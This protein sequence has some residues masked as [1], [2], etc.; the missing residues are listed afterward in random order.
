MARRLEGSRVGHAFRERPELQAALLFFVVASLLLVFAVLGEEI[1]EGETMKFDRSLA[2]TLR[3][4]G[5]GAAWTAEAARDLTSLG[6]TAVLGLITG[7]AVLYLLLLK[8]RIG[9]AVVFSTV[10]GGQILSSSLK[11]WFDRARP[12]LLPLPPNLS[13][14]FPSGH[15]M[16]S[17]VTYLTI[18]MLLT[19][20]QPAR[21]IRIFSVAVAVLM[22][23][24]VGLSRVYL[25][26]HWPTDVLGGWCLGSAWALLFGGF[27]MRMAR[28]YGAKVRA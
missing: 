23:V 11:A 25:G 10:F 16:M 7:V 13:A 5:A 22:I 12:D 14:S 2:N 21:S 20:T 18:A 8:D 27:I 17:A 15:S 24:V 9:S 4:L 3:A 1:T 6:S 28:K 26:Y 19:R